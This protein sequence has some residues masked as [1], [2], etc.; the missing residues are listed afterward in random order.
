MHASTGA[1]VTTNNVNINPFNGGSIGGLAD[2]NGRIIFSSGSVIQ[3]NWS[4]AASAQSGG[5]IIFQPGST[6]SPPYGGGVTAL[7]ANG[8]GSQ[9]TADGLALNMN[10]NGGS[11][12]AKAIAGGLI[13]LNEGTAISFAAGGG[14]NTGLLASGAGSQIVSNGATLSMPNSGGGDTGVRADSGGTATLN[15][16]SLTLGGGGGQTGLVANGAGS[17]IFGTDLALTVSSSG[18]RGGFLQDGGSV[19]LTGSSVTTTGGGSVG[20]LFQAAAG[21]TNTLALHGTT[22][23]SAAD[24]FA[25]QGGNAAIDTIGASVTGNNGFLMSVTQNAVVNMTSSQ[26]TL[27]GAITTAGGS[28]SNVGLS[29]G[30]VWNMTGNSTVTNLTNNDSDIVF[31][32]PASGTVFKTLTV[33]NYTGTGGTITLNTFLGADNSPSDQVIINGGTAT[34]LTGLKI[35]NAGGLGAETTANGILVVNATN[36]GT[37]AAGAFSLSGEA[38]AGAYDYFL[39]RGGLNGDAPNNWFLRSTFIVPPIDPPVPPIVPPDVLPPDPPPEVLPPGNEF[40]IIGPEIATYGVVQPI[41]RQLG[42]ATMG[43]LNQRIGDTMTLANAGSGVSG[44]GRSDWARLFGQGINDHYRAYA[45]PRASGWLGGFQGGIDLWRNTSPAGHRDAGGVYFS[46]AQANA[47]VTGLITN[48]SA[49]AYMLART[50][51]VNL[52]GYSFGGYWTHYGPNGWYLDAIIQGTIY[53]GLATTQFAQLQTDG[54]GLIG[55]LET[56]YPIPLPLGPSFVLEPQAQIIWQQV[57]FRDAN[58]GLGPVGLGTTSGPTGR[59][60]LRGQW[61]ID[62]TRGIRWQ[63]YLATNIWHSWGAQATTMFGIDRVELLETLTRT[64]VLAGVTAKLDRSF[65]LYAQAG[66]Q[67]VTGP[68]G[69][70]VRGGA[71]GNMGFRVAW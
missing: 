68:A 64:E 51:T 44:W 54:S 2:T 59:L 34:G 20:F 49:T 19:S 55:S 12:A 47:G 22:V 32:S 37:T 53:R 8:T 10:G 38:R 70:D 26:S 65:S 60:G 39:F 23:G 15:G 16:G 21:V 42:L 35:I 69:N 43:T 46:Y 11:V 17:N 7:V 18:S 13:T 67:F 71:L 30:T 4:T 62:D 52:T 3:G 6:I 50:G 57:S 24:A 25:V 1:Q 36:G 66:Y 56:G 61:T 28:A 58:D 41:A 5:Q 27:T 31:S 45:D 14:G 63:P 9:I 33:N 29:N 48:P 40:P